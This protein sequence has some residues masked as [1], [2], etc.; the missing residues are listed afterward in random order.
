MWGAPHCGKNVALPSILPPSAVPAL[1]SSPLPT[2]LERR[3]VSG[4]SPTTL[5]SPLPVSLPA[6]QTVSIISIQCARYD[7]MASTVN[8]KAFLFNR[9][10]EIFSVLSVPVVLANNWTAQKQKQNK[11]KINLPRSTLERVSPSGDENAALKRLFLLS[12]SDGQR[13]NWF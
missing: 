12:E 10:G 4:G 3:E 6:H 11:Q 2:R 8:Q 7:C 13:W 1:C 9:G 5:S